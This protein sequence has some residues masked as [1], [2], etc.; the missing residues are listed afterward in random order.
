M[1]VSVRRPGVLTTVQDLG[2]PGRRQLG[3]T[4]GGAMDP[5]SLRL[6][7]LLVGN[8]EN[9]AALEM[10]LHGAEL[11]FDHDALAAVCGG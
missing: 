11:H 9:F 3:F 2:R 7:N 8:P 10:T 6:A 1:E 5:L 4:P